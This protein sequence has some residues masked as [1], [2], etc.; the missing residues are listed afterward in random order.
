MEKKHYYGKRSSKCDPKQDLGEKYFSSSGDK[1]FLLDQKKNPQNYKYKIVQTFPSSKEAL[2]RESKLHYKFNVGLNIKFY[3]NCIQSIGGFDPT[4]RVLVKDPSGVYRSLYKDDERLKSTEFHP[5]A[6][7]RLITKDSNGRI[8][9]VSLDDPRYLSGE[10]TVWSKNK[11]N[12]R[13][14]DGNTF[15]VSKDDPRYLTGVLFSIMKDTVCVK[16]SIG[17]KFRTKLSDPRY[18]SGELIPVQRGESLGKNHW[19]FKGYYVTPFGN[20]ES[21]DSIGGGKFIANCC[22]SP[23]IVITKSMY[24]RT[25][26]LNLNF[27]ISIVGETFKSLGFD[28]IAK[29]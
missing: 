4:G 13:D 1:E 19:R 25:K 22:K 14:K 10:F 16:D 9:N 11:V 21:R 23:N 5:F 28:F 26:Y 18:L 29:S 27:P 15:Y 12:L 24:K 6:S 7:G 2:I 8:H 20:F 3:N 17:V